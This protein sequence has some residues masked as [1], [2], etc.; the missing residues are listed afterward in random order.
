MQAIGILFGIASLVS[1]FLPWEHYIGSSSVFAVAI[2]SFLGIENKS[3][4]RLFGLDF[5]P[6]TGTLIFILG[7]S[8]AKKHLA[9][10]IIALFGSLVCT[11]IGIYNILFYIFSPKI[12]NYQPGYGLWIFAIANLLALVLSIMILN[13]KEL[14]EKKLSG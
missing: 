1:V 2:S 11:I 7:F 4:D 12:P 6:I 8:L 13:K 3:L 14:L 9:W 10:R 5:L